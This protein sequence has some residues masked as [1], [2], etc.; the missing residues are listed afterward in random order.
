MAPPASFPVEESEIDNYMQG[1]QALIQQ[2]KGSL[3]ELRQ[4][5]KTFLEQQKR[6]QAIRNYTNALEPKYGVRILV[7]APFPPRVK[8]DTQGAPTLGPADAPVTIVEFSDYECPA[9]RSTHGVVKQVRAIYGDKVQWIYKEYPLARHKDAFKAAEAS[10]CAED[11]GKFWEYQ[12]KLFTAP[13]LSPANL[14]KIA[15]QLGMSQEKF[16]QCLEDS[17]YK[18]LVEKN[19]RDATQAGVDRTPS[20]MINGVVFAG[21]PALNTFRNM[22]DEELQKAG[23]KL[24]TVGSV[25]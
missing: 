2:F 19:V 11:Q 13:D 7:P 6:S 8:V 14:V 17:R 10:H 9:C 12:E 4:R 21:G 16:S 24:Q 25:K 15:V 20:F 23:A 5:I 1:N 18:P 3:P 22:I